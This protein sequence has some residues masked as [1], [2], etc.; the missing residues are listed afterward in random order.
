MQQRDMAW[1][2]DPPPPPPPPVHVP[3]LVL[4]EHAPSPFRQARAIS[5]R[6]SHGK[7]NLPFGIRADTGSHRKQEKF[8]WT[9]DALTV[10][11]RC[12]CVVKRLLT[13]SSILLCSILFCL[14]LIWLYSSYWSMNAPRVIQVL[15]VPRGMDKIQENCPKPARQREHG[16][17][18]ENSL[19]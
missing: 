14:V 6:I 3:N 8:V 13:R 19:P 7:L 17:R 11:R 1:S 5:T 10:N 12:R 9:L 16:H 18:G 2:S 4:K 15:E